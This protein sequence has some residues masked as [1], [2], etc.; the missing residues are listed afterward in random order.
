MRI[1]SVFVFALSCLLAFNYLSIGTNAMN[2]G[3]SFESSIVIQRATNQFSLDIAPKMVAKADSSFS[4]EVG[5]T[6]TINAVYSPSAASVDFGVVDPNGIFR[7]INVTDG[8]I[9]DTIQITKRGNYTFAVRN[10]SS[11]TITV[12]GFVQY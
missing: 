7:F 10:N 6:I 3:E 9:N 12:T 11:E 4:M 1:K 5:E 2:T 8:N